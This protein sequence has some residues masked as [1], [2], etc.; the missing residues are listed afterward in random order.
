[1]PILPF[2][3]KLGAHASPTAADPDPTHLEQVALELIKANANVEAQQN[4]GITALM[5]SCQNG[6]LEVRFPTQTATLDS[7]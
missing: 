5:L 6:H 7:L 4:E 2:F 3:A 1:M